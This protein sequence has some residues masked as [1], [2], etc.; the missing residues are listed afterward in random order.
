[1]KITISY[2]ADDALLA[3]AIDQT[4]KRLIPKA[5]RKESPPQSGFYH[6]IYS[7]ARKE[8]QKHE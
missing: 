4:L 6:I 5:R 3:D 1:M 7:T 8:K 2:N